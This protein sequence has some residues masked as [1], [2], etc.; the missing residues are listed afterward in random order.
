MG[1]RR[2][3]GVVGEGAAVEEPAIEAEPET[4]DLRVRIERR[5]QRSRTNSPSRSR[6][7][8]ERADEAA[9]EADEAAVEAELADV[10]AEEAVVEAAAR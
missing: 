2:R 7:A 3:Y 4:V 8:S 1:D 6:R 5:A 9:A 10:V